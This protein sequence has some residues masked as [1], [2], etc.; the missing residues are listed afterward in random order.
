MNVEKYDL[1]SICDSAR[2]LKFH[3]LSILKL[4]HPCK[5]E[6]LYIARSQKKLLEEMIKEYNF[7]RANKYIKEVTKW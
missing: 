2:I 4:I 1:G 7:I 5:K 3:F 6:R